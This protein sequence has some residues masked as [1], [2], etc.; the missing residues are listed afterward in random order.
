MILITCT[1]SLFSQ[2]L[3]DSLA[4]LSTFTKYT[5]AESFLDDE[6]Y[7]AAL[8]IYLDLI[9]RDADNSNLNFKVGFCYLNT[10]LE[11]GKAISF[12]EKAI[13]NYSENYNSE[14][15]TE[16]VAPIESWYFLGSAYHVNHRFDEALT[17]LNKLML[18]IT[19]LDTSFV[20][21]IKHYINYC[22]NAKE[23]IKT[24][25]DIEITN[26][27][28]SIN[29]IYS[30]HSPVFSA[31]ESVLIFTS[32][33][34]GTTG[35]KL[36]ADGQYYEDI[37]ISFKKNGKWSSPKGIGANINTDKHEASIS[38]SVDGQQLLIYRDDNKDGNIYISSLN[39]DIWNTPDKLGPTVN[40]KYRESH[41]SLSADG[42][43]LYLASARPGGFGGMD[44]YVVK[45]LPNGEWG[46]AQNLGP[47]VNT[48]Y[49][50]D[51]P[52]IHPDGVT[53]FFSSQG[54]NSMG[55][56]DI[57]YTNIDNENKKC[58]TSAN[59]GYPINTTDDDVFYNPT[60]DGKYAYYS[61]FRNGGKGQ[62]DIYLLKIPEGDEKKL[63]VMTGIIT[64]DG[65]PSSDVTLSV[66]DSESGESVGSYSPNSKSGKY[67][68]VLPSDKKYKIEVNSNKGEN[69]T[70][71][72][73]PSNDSS[74]YKIHRPVNLE[75]INFGKLVYQAIFKGTVK[76]NQTL[77]PLA[78]NIEIFDNSNNQQVEIIET[79]NKN[80]EFNT[81]LISGKNYG[82]SVKADGY[83]FISDNIDLSQ[84]NANSEISK[85]ILLQ[86]AE[87]ASKIILKN[88]FFDF[89][90]ATL[91]K[92]S[93]HEL[94]TLIDLLK[95]Q[96][97]TLK[98]EISGHTDNKGS[99]KSNTT[100]S[101]NRA[102]SVVNFLV[103]HEIDANRLTYKGYA[104]NEPIAPNTTDEGRQMNRRVEFKILSK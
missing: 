62:N 8:P 85:E 51:G 22:L 83:M 30:E 84:S 44:I 17:V 100:L 86:K 69:K 94:N 81:I 4:K 40:T 47:N 61:S 23:L 12:L 25:V 67:L 78:A 80:G 95:N 29:T 15:Y 70:F 54:H 14:A 19:P 65:K 6:N 48:E 99:L 74:Y 72:I 50:E 101:T 64:V 103:K 57:F 37:Y 27:G 42:K 90:K 46:E 31:D 13:L 26:L 11:K 39:G 63:T 76:D 88:I 98:I 33:R 77:T 20:K 53:L 73:N 21:D 104:F 97:P 56:F 28:D 24:P 32:K 10:H 93:T 9:S 45:K 60:P 92:E 82:I 49:D 66:T 16:K 79:G 59:L 87:V 102:K 75:P 38:L 35:G 58:S 34:S 55:G 96:Y 89:N 5:A 41:A 36:T 71:D 1:I 68:L 3:P 52:F 7:N 91:R 2:N 43:A 18:I